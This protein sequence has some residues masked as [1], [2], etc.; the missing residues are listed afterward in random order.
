M[1]KV[2]APDG[3]PRAILFGAAVHNTTLRSDFY[4]ICADYAGFAQTF[5][6]QKHPGAVA[7]F[8]LGC[9]G[10][11]DP[12]PFGNMELARQHGTALGDEV[13]RVLS[14]PKKLLPVRGPLQVAFAQVDLPLQIGL[15]RDELQKVAAEKRNARSWGAAQM[16][17][18]LDR[19]EKLP[20]HYACPLSVWQFGPWPHCDGFV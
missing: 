5:V 4:Q 18:Q 12:Y 2:A 19:G 20:T 1:L 16:V 15:S 11:A 17:A 13:C 7:M 9:A 3:T 8:A 6:E 10:D 14:T